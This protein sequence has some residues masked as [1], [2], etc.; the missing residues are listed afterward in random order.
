MIRETS[1]YA[2]LTACG[3][4]LLYVFISIA[5]TGGYKA[6]EN[7]PGILFIEVALSAGVFVL[8]VERLISYLRRK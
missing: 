5:V 7:N 1:A 2:I 3:A 8:G 6:V 4:G